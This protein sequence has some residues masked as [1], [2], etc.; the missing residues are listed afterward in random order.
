[1]HGDFEAELGDSELEEQSVLEVPSLSTSVSS[2][3][4]SEDESE[5]A[6]LD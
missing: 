6:L 2:V 4:G 3:V 1:M 5:G